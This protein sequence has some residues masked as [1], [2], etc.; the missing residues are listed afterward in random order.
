MP[1]SIVEFLNICT[2][3]TIWKRYGSGFLEIIQR[4]AAQLPP[5][6]PDELKNNITRS[7]SHHF[8]PA[9]SMINRDNQPNKSNGKIKSMSTFKKKVL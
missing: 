3:E 5:R 8:Q 1:I 6:L 2:N 9:S 4:Y 7:S